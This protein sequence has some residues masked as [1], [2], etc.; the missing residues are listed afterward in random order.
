[1]LM[2]RI[3]YTSRTPVTAVRY[4]GPCTETAGLSS[5]R[6][7]ALLS[8]TIR[9]FLRHDVPRHPE[10]PV[11]RLSAATRI[12]RGAKRDCHAHPYDPRLCIKVP[13]RPHRPNAQQASIVEWYCAQSLDRRRVPYRHRARC[14]GWVATDRGAGLVMERVYDGDGTPAPTLYDAV[15]KHRLAHEQIMPLFAELKHWVLVNGVP[16]TDLNSANLVV[17]QHDSRPALVLIDGIG[18][19]KVK[20][21]FVLYRRWPWFARAISR[22]RWARLEQVACQELTA[23]LGA[24][25]VDT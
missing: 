11:Y 2:L 16:V 24:A 6:D 8:K 10:W 20:I 4:R 13:R 15:R 23:P 1:M 9:L 17:R 12:G 22:R 3:N 14:V 21:K 25:G 19:Q 18:G 7:M 5:R